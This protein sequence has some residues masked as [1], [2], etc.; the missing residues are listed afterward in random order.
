MSRLRLGYTDEETSR[1]QIG[2]WSDVYHE[3]RTLYNFE[4]KGMIYKDV[5]DE[6]QEFLNSHIEIKPLSQVKEG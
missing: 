3:Y 6:Q 2:Y 1:M 5:E 4:K